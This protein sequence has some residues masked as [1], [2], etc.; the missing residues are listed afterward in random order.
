MLLRA[1]EQER[2]VRAAEKGGEVVEE[3]VVRGEAA[4]QD[5]MLLKEE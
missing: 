1:H 2:R 5:D 4:D 3:P